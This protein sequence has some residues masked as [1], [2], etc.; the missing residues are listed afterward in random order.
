MFKHP[1]YDFII[2]SAISGKHDKTVA[3]LKQDVTTN[4][5]FVNDKQLMP[6]L[7]KHLKWKSKFY[8]MVKFIINGCLVSDEMQK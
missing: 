3:S 6:Y 7:T 4:V 2:F 5:E 1:Y 8:T